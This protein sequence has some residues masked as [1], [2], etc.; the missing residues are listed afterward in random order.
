MF[1]SAYSPALGRL[2]DRK[3]LTQNKNSGKGYRDLSL[4]LRWG[5][6]IS[7][8]PDFYSV[9]NVARNLR[10]FI[11]LPY[12]A[13]S[14]LGGRQG[15]N[16]CTIIAVKFGDYCIQHKLHVSLFWTQLP[17]LW[18]SLFANA[19]CDGNEMYDEVYGAT[20]VYLDAEDV[21]QSLGTECNVQS[22]RNFWFYK[23]K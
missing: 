22:Q 4:K 1:A 14:S 21:A 20:A 6:T 12:V 5:L 19:I 13:Q 18:T 23:C 16:A 11:F 15:N 10:Q 8:R 7:R 2:I 3:S 17:Q 9:H